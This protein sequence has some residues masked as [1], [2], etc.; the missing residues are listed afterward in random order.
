METQEIYELFQKRLHQNLKKRIDARIFIS[1]ENDT[2]FIRMSKLGVY[3]EQQIPN[4]LDIILQ[5]AGNDKLENEI[6]ADFRSM[7][8]KTFFY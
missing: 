4:I 1:I 3:W 6:I 5:G 7:V 8:F 2:L